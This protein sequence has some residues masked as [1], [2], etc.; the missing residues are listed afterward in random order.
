MLALVG[1]LVRY[2]K[3]SAVTMDVTVVTFL[4]W[5]LGF[6]GT[7]LLPF[8][9][10]IT[11]STSEEE[12]HSLFPL[13]QAI[14]WSTFILAWGILP[15]QMQYH[16]SGEFTVTGKLCEAIKSNL[17]TLL[18]EVA[19]V[20]LFII[21]MIA[22]KGSKAT[23]DFIAFAMA[24][25][26]TYGVLF[27][28]L[29]MGNGL[30]SLPRRL[31][32]IGNTEFEINR[33]Y[34]LAISIES[35]FHD[36]RFDLEDCE[37]DVQNMIQAFNLPESDSSLKVLCE[38]IKKLVDNFPFAL[39][40][41]SNKFR[42][43]TQ[44]EIQ[45]I[46]DRST[47]VTLHARVKTS[48]LRVTAAER[49]WKNLL[50]RVKLLQSLQDGSLKAEESGWCEMKMITAN[51]EI[52]PL[53]NPF[54]LFY[55]TLRLYWI[56]YLFLWACRILSILCGLGSLLIFYSELGMT[57]GVESPISAI[58]VAL[59]KSGAGIF[60]I[61]LISLMCLAYMSLCTFWSL[62]SMNLGWSYTLNGPHQSPD[63]SLLFN[64][65]YLARLQFS[66]GYNFLLFLNSK[67][68]DGTSFQKLMK[69]MEIIP[70][71]GS[72][73][74]VYA[75]IITAIIGV[76]TYFNIYSR[77][78]KC[79]GIQVEDS[80]SGGDFCQGK[81]AA[82]I[83]EIE[84]G[85]KLVAG[86]LRTL[87]HLLWSSDQKRDDSIQLIGKGVRRSDEES[88][89]SSQPRS[90]ENDIG[91]IQDRNS[92]SFRDRARVF[93]SPSKPAYVSLR[94]SSPGVDLDS[95]NEKD[96]GRTQSHIVDI[97][98]NDWSIPASTKKHGRYG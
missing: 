4:S 33:L 23:F 7:I 8:D 14:Y 49:R 25:G 97:L 66:L 61:Q 34:L 53:C 72:S 35:S 89:D 15:L 11:L 20:I 27:I 55:Q 81:S 79:A 56:K 13:W 64:S 29:L 83:E 51:Q 70:L 90:E 47:L 60:P 62:F 58:I 39:R 88:I 92:L 10:A 93:T 38:I 43:V 54:I 6:A 31:W 37:T 12:D 80:V 24:M 17:Q 78:I 95:S 26:N 45:P 82:E 40:S 69:N 94:G 59:S 52:N 63:S 41:A 36:A 22:I 21:Y 74:A 73:F 91:A 9:M 85:K 57:L 96:S 2:Y 48:Q 76:V 86:Q 32:T 75:P 30:V 50:I 19:L 18:I 87:G 84:A 1:Y 67:G 71:F 28:I 42:H 46:T 5:A 68:I 44:K 16:L 98:G 65:N 77:L 3:S